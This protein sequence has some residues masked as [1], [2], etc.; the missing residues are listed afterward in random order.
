MATLRHLTLVLVVT[1]SAVSL[2][3]SQAQ[4]VLDQDYSDSRYDLRILERYLD[5]VCLYA[6]MYIKV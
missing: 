6:E 2:S 5:N 1:I 3:N 4:D